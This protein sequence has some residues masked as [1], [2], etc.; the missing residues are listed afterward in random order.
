MVRY[1]G[2][3]EEAARSP[4]KAIGYSHRDREERKFLKLTFLSRSV[5]LWHGFWFRVSLCGKGNP[6]LGGGIGFP[7]QLD[8]GDAVRDSEAEVSKPNGRTSS[9]ALLESNTGDQ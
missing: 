3:R 2:P 7:G 5:S 4:R 1:C 6:T 8:G 9:S